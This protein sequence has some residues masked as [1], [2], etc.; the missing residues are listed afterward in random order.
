M[1]KQT[2]YHLVLDRSGSMDSCWKEARQ[3]FHSQLQ[4]F[5]EK[6]IEYADQDLFFSYC[7]FNQALKFSPGI[8]PIS[9]AEIDWR[10]IYPNGMTSLYDAIGSSIQYLKSKLRIA[11]ENDKT[12]VVMLIL[13][14]GFENSSKI[15]NAHEVKYL[16]EELELNEKWTFLF[17]GAGLNVEEATKELNRKGKNS[18]SFEKNSIENSIDF[19]SEEINDFLALK[20]RGVKKSAFFKTNSIK[21]PR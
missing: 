11:L 12:D 1:K 9:E 19:V 18:F 7:A 21:K 8:V 4:G 3:S 20:S 2:Y 14:D 13:T 6:Q 17:L 16:I 10:E 15:F 5:K